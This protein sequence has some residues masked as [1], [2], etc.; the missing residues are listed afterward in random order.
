MKLIPPAALLLLAGCMAEAGGG[1]DAAG[2]VPTA[3]QSAAACVADGGRWAPGGLLP[4]RLCFLPT[5]DAGK[6][7]AR[8]SDCSAVCLSDTRTCSAESPIFGCY[9]F[10]DE[11]GVEIMICTD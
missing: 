2:A 6:S 1:S 9:G 4:D 11:G 10:L 8:A 3:P 5:P 7:C